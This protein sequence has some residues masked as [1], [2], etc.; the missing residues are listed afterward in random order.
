[1]GR[2]NIEKDIIAIDALMGQAAATSL[3][4]KPMYNIKS[5]YGAVGDGAT[6]DTTALQQAIDAAISGSGVLV[7]PPGEYLHTTTLLAD[8][9]FQ[10]WGSARTAIVA[11]PSQ[12][13]ATRWTC[14]A[15]ARRATTR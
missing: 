4:A 2:R 14:P 6:D 9:A 5:D 11:L 15:A 13:P 1:L 12:A 3:V 8:H 7:V 10:F